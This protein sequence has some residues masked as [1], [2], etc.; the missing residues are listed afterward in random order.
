MLLAFG[1]LFCHHVCPI[2]QDD[3]GQQKVP[4]RTCATKILPN[5]RENF[6]ARF[7][8]KPLFYWV[9][10]SNCSENS[11]VQFVRLFGFEVLLAPE[12]RPV[13]VMNPG[14]VPPRRRAEYCF[15]SA[16]SEE[17]TR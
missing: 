14:L 3:Q 10:P 9:V 16:A 17:R 11:L 1:L 7:V 12:M 13:P 8:S 6:L 4:Q 2:C 5:F 15:E